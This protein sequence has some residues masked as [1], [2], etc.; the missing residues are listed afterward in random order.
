[1]QVDRAK[2]LAEYI[3][4]VVETICQ[5]NPGSLAF[6]GDIEY[7]VEAGVAMIKLRQFAVSVFERQEKSE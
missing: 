1:M 2:D 7:F 6:Q 4:Q 3:K 5:D